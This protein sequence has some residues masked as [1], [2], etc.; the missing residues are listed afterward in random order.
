[1]TSANRAG[2]KKGSGGDNFMFRPGG[3]DFDDLFERARLAKK[4]PLRVVAAQRFEEILLNHCF[5]ALRGHLHAERSCNTEHRLD[6]GD[7]VASPR[8]VSD[9]ASIDF[10]LIQWEFSE[11]TQGGVTR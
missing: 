10:D 9:E 8:R 7:L 5:N 4:K 2:R 3:D 1:M 6:D 11:K